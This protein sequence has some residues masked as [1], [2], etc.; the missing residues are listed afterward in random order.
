MAWYSAG[1]V[2]VTNGSATV[3]G[4]GTAWVANAQAGEA[5]HG[6]DKNIYEIVS[7]NSNTSLT[8]SP[9]YLGTTRSGEGYSI[10]PV[11]GYPLLAAQQMAALISTVQGYVDGA[12]S[13]RFGNGTVGA[14][15]I[16]FAS[17]TAMGIFRVAANQ[18]GIATNGVRR[19]LLSNTAM[20]V[21]VPITGSAVQA[22]PADD[23]AG[24]LMP[25]GAFSL[26]GLVV[27]RGTPPGNDLNN[28]TL[29]GWY[30]IASN[31]LNSPMNGQN[32]VA[33]VVA[34]T[35]QRRLQVVYR[36]AGQAE[37]E[38]Y[39]RVS[40]G[41]GTVYGD[42]V[43]HSKPVRG[44][45]ANGEY[46][47]Y[48]DGTMECWHTID[49]GDTRANGA[50][51]YA[52]PYRSNAINWTY[53]ASFLS[54]PAVEACCQT[55]ASGVLRG[56]AAVLRYVTVN[57]SNDMQVFRLSSSSAPSSGNPTYLHL[58]AVGRWF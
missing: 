19:V 44:S 41:D 39:E 12:L 53:P 33:Y 57:Y 55:D 43:P 2:S 45:N 35:A 18:L 20:Q 38:A 16:S 23:T 49:A 28:A 22:A 34:R 25:V 15:G 6:P 37:T 13:G 36:I 40:Y 30:D 50:G 32:G 56:H 5:F 48:A 52:D 4:S 24:K 1:T 11:K 29:T 9:G 42:W 47:R 7:V 21:D 17:N 31:T 58:R 10:L 26:G 3:T 8:I 27:N 51:T 46:V 54:V 14:P